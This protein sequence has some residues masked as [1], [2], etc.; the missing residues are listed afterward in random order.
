MIIK[1]KNG[2]FSVNTAQ[3]N[4]LMSKFNFDCISWDIINKT[5]FINSSW[6]YLKADE[7]FEKNW[8]SFRNELK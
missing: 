5:N 4:Y 3:F 2:E 7:Y 6:E 8:R 1:N